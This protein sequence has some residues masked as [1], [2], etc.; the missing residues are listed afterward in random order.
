MSEKITYFDKTQFTNAGQPTTVDIYNINDGT[1][2]AVQSAVIGG[3]CRDCGF[4]HEGTC[5]PASEGADFVTKGQSKAAK[6]RVLH[7]DGTEAGGNVHEGC[8]LVGAQVGFYIDGDGYVR[9][10]LIQ[11]EI[12]NQ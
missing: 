6:L 10:G 1:F 4:R 3:F 7:D 11:E 2:D 12:S 9:T 8:P 5:S